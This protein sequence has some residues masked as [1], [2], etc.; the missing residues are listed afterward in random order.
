[1]HAWVYSKL[2]RKY[3]NMLPHCKTAPWYHR[4]SLSHNH[5]H[6]HQRTVNKPLLFYCARGCLNITPKH[7]IWHTTVCN[8]DSMRISILCVR[9]MKQNKHLV[10]I[11]HQTDLFGSLKWPFEIGSDSLKWQFEI[12]LISSWICIIIQLRIYR[13]L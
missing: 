10:C 2:V 8:K 9:N 6:S 12:T 4:P 3:W 5:M 7:T 1:M 11:S 13:C